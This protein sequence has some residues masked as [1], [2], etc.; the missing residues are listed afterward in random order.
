MLHPWQAAQ[1]Q[2]EETVRV[3]DDSGLVHR[4]HQFGPR[5]FAKSRPFSANDSRVRARDRFGKARRQ[6]EA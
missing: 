4:A 2:V 1:F 5:C 3:N 6:S